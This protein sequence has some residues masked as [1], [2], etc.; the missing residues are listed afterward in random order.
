MLIL[1][2]ERAERRRLSSMVH[3]L[4]AREINIF[5]AL[6]FHHSRDAFPA[7]E[8]GSSEQCATITSIV[9]VFV[10]IWPRDLSL[11]E[12]RKKQESD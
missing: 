7:H 5:S 1:A 8:S 10:V 6:S 12:A 3:H 9:A 4:L 11:T 2:E